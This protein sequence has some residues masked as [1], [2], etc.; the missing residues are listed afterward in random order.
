MVGERVDI[1]MQMKNRYVRVEAGWACAPVVMGGGGGVQ[2]LVMPD[3]TMEY[4]DL[5]ICNAMGVSG[6]RCLPCRQC[7]CL[8]V[9]S[10]R[11]GKLAMLPKWTACECTPYTIDVIGSI[12]YCLAIAD[13]IKF[14]I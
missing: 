6:Y 2:G 3:M 1:L 12:W 7:K 11:M 10:K 14:Q 13:I 9:K 4:M 8:G 5:A